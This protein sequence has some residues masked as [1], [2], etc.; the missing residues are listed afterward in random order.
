VQLQLA[1]GS[2]LCSLVSM[3]GHDQ[4]VHC[5]NSACCGSCAIVSPEFARGLRLGLGY[6][7]LEGGAVVVDLCYCWPWCLS[8][9]VSESRVSLIFRKELW[10][11][12]PWII[13]DLKEVLP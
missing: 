1:L 9:L 8:S 2:T 3:S 10:D 11:F 4:P 13:K 6:M 5:P 7:G 12:S